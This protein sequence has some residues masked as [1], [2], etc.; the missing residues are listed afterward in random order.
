MPH[1]FDIYSE[2][3]M[4]QLTGGKRKTVDL[5]P[6]KM[7]AALAAVER[8]IVADGPSNPNNMNASFESFRKRQENPDD[9]LQIK[10]DSD[11]INGM[12]RYEYSKACRKELMKSVERSVRQTLEWR[13]AAIRLGLTER[14]GNAKSIDTHRW[15]DKLMK[16]DGSPESLEYNESIVALAA[17][18]NKQMTEQQ[19]VDWRVTYYLRKKD[20]VNWK[21]LGAAEESNAFAA[22]AKDR[23]SAGDFIYGEVRKIVDHTPLDNYKIA[24]NAIASGDFSNEIF[25]GIDENKCLEKAFEILRHDAVLLGSEAK[26]MFQILKQIGGFNLSQEEQAKVNTDWVSKI[27]PYV[28][29]G[30]VANLTANPYFAIIDPYKHYRSTMPTPEVPVNEMKKREKDVLAY[31]VIGEK[32]IYEARAAEIYENILKKYEVNLYSE[33]DRLQ[34]ISV[35][36]LKNTDTVVILEFTP[37]TAN[38]MVGVKVCDRPGRLVSTDMSERVQ[39]LLDRCAGWSRE[40]HT[41]TGFSITLMWSP[42]PETPIA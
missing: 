6:E 42:S 15:M 9:Y 30:N 36:N 25:A 14:N 3:L 32:T 31:S 13:N 38:E 35:H 28:G 10:P 40:S 2:L 29:I 27:Y 21:N 37:T 12:S 41:L 26:M 17:L 1:V 22:A 33:V 34:G 24:V 16:T 11:T 19:Y 20:P 18:G 8:K 39:G 7:Q 23:N 5:S 4:K